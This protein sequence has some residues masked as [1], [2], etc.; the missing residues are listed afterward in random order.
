LTLPGYHVWEKL[1]AQRFCISK[2]IKV[3]KQM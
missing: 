1:V 3:A 2:K